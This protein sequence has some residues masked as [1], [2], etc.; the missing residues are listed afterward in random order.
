MGSV[1]VAPVSTSY[2]SGMLE[3]AATQEEID[4]EFDLLPADGDG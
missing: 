4:D 3:R 2:A 1:G